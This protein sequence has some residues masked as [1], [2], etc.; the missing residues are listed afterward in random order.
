M[1]PWSMALGGIAGMGSG[2]LNYFGN[3]QTNESNQFI[4]SVN[5]AFNADQA[6]INRNFQEYMSNTAYQRS[7]SDMAKAGLN[8]ILAATKGGASTP[9]GAA[10][11]ANPI[12]AQ[13]TKP[14][15]ILSS[16]ASS[17]L[18]AGRLSMQANM[19]EAD[20]A[21]KQ[22]QK[23]A[24]EASSAASIAS[25]KEAAAKTAT[26]NARLPGEA[27]ES[28][29]KAVRGKYDKDAA[30]YDA[31]FNRVQSGLGAA[32]SALDL[33]KPRIKIETIKN[34]TPSEYYRNEQQKRIQQR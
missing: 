23:T 32:N 13:N 22:S 34:P 15:D 8:P 25:A 4:S 14:G 29:V 7:M 20:I 1:D 11:S 3:Q 28:E 6:Q 16:M 26:L 19:Q 33:V 18:D 17:A 21:L 24:A 9:S 5:N 2:V 12:P 27:A 30:G 10:A 31:I